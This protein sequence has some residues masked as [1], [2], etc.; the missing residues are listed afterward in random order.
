[1]LR[2]A[3]EWWPPCDSPSALAAIAEALRDGNG[4]GVI[5][6][7]HLLTTTEV[8]DL[9]NV[10]RP[11]LVRLLDQG[12]I[13]FEKVGTHRRVR[14]GDVLAHRQERDEQ[15]RDALGNLVRQRSAE[16]SGGAV[17]SG[18]R[19]RCFAATLLNW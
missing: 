19:M 1:M 13:P 17:A 11:Y 10:S 16:I 6:L 9:L 15:R 5:P 8:A 2:A 18:P 14:L 3:R 7:P 12:K 4:V